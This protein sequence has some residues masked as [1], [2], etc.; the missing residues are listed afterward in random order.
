MPFPNFAISGA[1]Y[2]WGKNKPSGE[3]A[4]YPKPVSDLSGWQIRSIGCWYVLLPVHFLLRERGNY[5]LSLLKIGRFS[6]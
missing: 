1:L 5:W 2:L 3:A 6:S 4:M